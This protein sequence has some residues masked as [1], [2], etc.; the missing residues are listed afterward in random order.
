MTLIALEG[1][2]GAG[3]STL[4]DAVIKTLKKRYPKDDIEYLHFSQLKQDPLDEYAFP[5]EGYEPDSGI[6]FVCD[7]FHWGELIYG[8]LYRSQSA[9]SKAAYRWVELYLAARGATTWHVTASLETVQERL[10]TRGEDYLAPEDV[11]HVWGRFTAVS[12][13]AL[14]MGGTAYTDRWDTWD[15][16]DAIVNDA[17]Y[18]DQAA[19]EVFQPEYIGRS[20]P[21]VVL[22]GDAQGNSDPGI[23]KAPFMP[24]GGSCGTFLFEALPE[25]WWHQL[26]IVNANEADLAKIYESR[27]EPTFVALGS[28][29]AKAL[30]ALDLPHGTVPHPQ[31]VRRFNHREQYSYGTLIRQAAT[32]MGDYLKWPNL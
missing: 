12:T 23:T 21:T 24:R 22:V 13:T 32:D 18:K 9:L 14:T 5:F 28:N 6:H 16:A 19:A 20:L 26:G 4:A 3:K 29:A 17:A 8:P 11:E 2:D 30:D 7:R 25:T 31:K 27:F 10:Q 1:P 15:I